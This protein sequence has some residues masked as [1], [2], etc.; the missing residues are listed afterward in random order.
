MRAFP[1]CT[2]TAQVFPPQQLSRCANHAKRNCERGAARLSGLYPA[3]YPRNSHDGAAESSDASTL[4]PPEPLP[5]NKFLAPYAILPGANSGNS[6]G[7]SQ[8]RIEPNR[9]RS[10]PRTPERADATRCMSVSAATFAPE[11]RYKPAVRRDP[12]APLPTFD[13]DEDEDEETAAAPGQVAPR[14][15]IVSRR[16]YEYAAELT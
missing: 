13:L 16:L 9:R 10:L 5:H 15:P 3:L 11:H 6:L 8:Q 7:Y 1:L 12:Q 14:R 2:T 4:Q